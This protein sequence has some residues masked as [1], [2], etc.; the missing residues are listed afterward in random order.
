MIDSTKHIEINT[1]IV[2]QYLYE[3]IWKNQNMQIKDLQFLFC[4]VILAVIGASVNC[5]KSAEGIDNITSLLLPNGSSIA[6]TTSV[7]PQEMIKYV[8]NDPDLGTVRIN[9]DECIGGY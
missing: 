3:S 2:D 9:K 7:T 4:L 5:M 6:V 8:M 1:H